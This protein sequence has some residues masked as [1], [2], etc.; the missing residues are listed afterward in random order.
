MSEISPQGSSDYYLEIYF[1]P[2]TKE[3]EYQALSTSFDLEIGF[4]T[5]E[6]VSEE[7]ATGGGGYVPPI[8]GVVTRII[9]TS[10]PTITS[11]SAQIFCSTDIL[12]FCRVIYDTLSHPVLGAPPNYGY[13]WSTDPGPKAINHT[14]EIEGL[15]PDTVYYYRIVCWASPYKISR[16]YSFKTERIVLSQE[17]GLPEE[18]ILPQPFKEKEI[19]EITFRKPFFEEEK[20]KEE[21]PKEEI[22]VSTLP[23]SPT[24]SYQEPL[25]KEPFEPGTFE[26]A[27]LMAGIKEIIGSTPKLIF[28]LILLLILGGI[29]G[30]NLYLFLK[31]K[32]EKRKNP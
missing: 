5:R 29:L 12:A 18:E 2:Q 3:K 9:I 6:T 24:P 20:P 25:V 22:F 13:R 4:F 31:A 28:V 21:E 8:Q 10:P 15:L 16:E 7:P 14:I 23:T 19:S 27:G 26:G 11:D 32:R 1:S 17:E 30:R